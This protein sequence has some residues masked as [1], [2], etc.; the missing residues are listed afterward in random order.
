MRKRY[1]IWLTIIVILLIFTIGIGVLK[2]FIG[3]D[4]NKKPQNVTSIITSIDEFGYTLDDRDTDYMKTEFKKLEEV[5]SQE[6]INYEEYAKAIAKLFVI[7]F[8][9]LNNKINKYDVGSLEYILSDKKDMFKN[10]AMDT[11]YGDIIDNT[12]KDRVQDLPEVTA[13]EIIN[14][15]V[16]EITLNKNK[17]ESYKLTMKYTYKKDLG[18]D[19]EG[20]IYLVKN[21]NKLEVALYNP[22]ID[23]A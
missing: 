14:Y 1:K 22:K 20:T 21:N 19:K 4:N 3:S 12:Y 23:K 5:I 15:E 6:E 8:Y 7:D 11:I 2:L 18:Y 16:T 9:T 10:K 17:V 13:V